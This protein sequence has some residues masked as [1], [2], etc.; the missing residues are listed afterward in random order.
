[1]RDID[2]GQSSDA[3]RLRT[4]AYVAW[5]VFGGTRNDPEADATRHW[6]ITHAPRDLDDPYTLALLCNALLAIDGGSAHV[7]PYLDRLVELQQQSADGKLVWWGQAAGRSTMFYGGGRAGDV[8]TTAIASLALLTAPWDIARVDAGS[9]R[10]TAH[11]ALSWIA[12]QRDA[13]GTWLSTQATVL[14]LKALLTG[15]ARPAT[16]DTD[17]RVQLVLDDG[18]PQEIVI[19]AWQS[20]LVQTVDLSDRL[21]R[22]PHRVRLTDRTDVAPTFQVSFAYHVPGELPSGK[23]AG[24][25]AIDMEYDR[26]ELDQYQ[27]VTATALVR[28]RSDATLPMVVLD[29]PIPP[30]FAVDPDE[31]QSVVGQ[32]Q[33]EKVQVTPRTA[34]VYLRSLAP[35]VE[36]QFSYDL[37]ATLPVVATTEPAVAYEYYTPEHRAESGRDRLTVRSTDD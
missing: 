14:A 26:R 8:E 21:A 23:S 33:I 1:M 35:G 13:Y 15:T 34:I 27:T 20:E 28:N 2:L 9:L 7:R 32:R 3:A 19:P 29:L 12:A 31:F 25:L 6:L 17:R 5:A 10:L 37:R 18:D 24:P 11:R 4:T 30:G 22:G 36:L 16:A